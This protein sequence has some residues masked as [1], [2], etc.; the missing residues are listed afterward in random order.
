MGICEVV[1]DEI[2]R[3]GPQH[4]HLQ[5][6]R[7]L[8]A[9]VILKLYGFNGNFDDFRRYLIAEPIGVNATNFGGTSFSP[10]VRVWVDFGAYF[11]WYP[12]DFANVRDSGLMPSHAAEP[13][14]D[15]PAYVIDARHGTQTIMGING[16]TPAIA[17]SHAGLG[18][19][20]RQKQLE[21]HPTRKYLEECRL[22]WEEYGQKLKAGPLPQ[23][24]T[25]FALV[26]ELS[27][28]WSRAR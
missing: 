14:Y 9:Q 16:T 15:R 17:E 8:E 1:E 24:Q 10:G 19:V 18:L 4:V 25:G 28:T 6:G 5:S 13:E 26:A 27:D 23:N 11:L 12:K 20:K 3:V 22:E 21:C 2:K 7:K